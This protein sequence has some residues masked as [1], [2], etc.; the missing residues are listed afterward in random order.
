MKYFYI[1]DIHHTCDV[2]ENNIESKPKQSLDK[3]LDWIEEIKLT[4]YDSMSDVL[5]NLCSQW[6]HFTA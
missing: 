6:H 4:I 1:K 2:I 3:A 5:F